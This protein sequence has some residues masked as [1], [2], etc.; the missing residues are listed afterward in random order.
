MEPK[1][2]TKATLVDLLDR[3]LDKGIVIHAD[4]I[5]SVAGIP[6]IGV[7]LKAALAGMETMLKYGMMEE[8]D[9]STRSRAMEKEKKSL[10]FIQEEILFKEK[11]SYYCHEGIVQTWRFGDMYLT[12][13]QLVMYH[14]VFEDIMFEL[15]LEKIK[16]I[17]VIEKHND[18][19]EN[20][21][22]VYILTHDNEIERFKTK[23][24]AV[25]EKILKDNFLKDNKGY[26]W[27][28]QS[29]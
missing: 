14:P 15:G 6:L 13:R 16:D 9:A 4:M 8:W 1:S 24:I 18:E 23:N 26:L 10:H 2:Y 20:Q 21:K 22:Q 29:A 27:A 3:V 25:F 12:H 17:E 11:A 19:F 7:N 5:I 28:E